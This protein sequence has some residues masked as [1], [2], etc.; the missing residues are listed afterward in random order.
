MKENAKDMEYDFS[1]IQLRE[2]NEQLV[3]LNQMNELKFKAEMLAQ[4]HAA[5]VKDINEKVAE[6][7][8]LMT[9]QP[10]P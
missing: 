10:D 7:E 8:R 3:Q 9:D 2:E 1:N 6:L 5:E 4:S